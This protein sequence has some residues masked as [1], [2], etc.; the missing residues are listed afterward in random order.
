[1][2][3]STT[4]R[5]EDD[6]DGRLSPEPPDPSR[7]AVPIVGISR[8]AKNLTTSSSSTEPLSLGDERNYKG[9]RPPL[10]WDFAST[11]YITTSPN[12]SKGV[13]V[14]GCWRRQVVLSLG[15]LPSLQRAKGE[16][17]KGGLPLT[18]IRR[19]R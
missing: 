11:Q 16:G 18:F 13:D 3:P 15:T 6:S 9:T 10:P 2:G 1:M 19:W 8:R 17:Q 5:A 4:Q 7:S 14:P 12:A